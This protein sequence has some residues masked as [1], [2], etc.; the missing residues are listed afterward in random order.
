MH[1]QLFAITLAVSL[2]AAPLPALAVGS[3]QASDT[4][5]GLATTV[6]ASGLA[7][8][9]ADIVVRSP[10]G[11]DVPLSTQVDANGNASVSIPGNALEEAGVYEVTV[12]QQSVPLPASAHFA[13]K[14]G[15][16]DA[17]NSAVEA[18]QTQVSAGQTTEVRV[19]LRDRYANPLAGR[20]V[21]LVA[22]RPSDTV[23]QLTDLTDAAGMQRFSVQVREAGQTTLTAL[24]LLS[25]T[26]VDAR[27]TLW[28]GGMAAMGGDALIASIVPTAHAQSVIKGFELTLPKIA[29]LKEPFA[30][31]IRAVDAQGNL[32]PDYT[33]SVYVSVSNDANAIL[34]GI[35]TDRDGYGKLKFLVQSQGDLNVPAA[36]T[37]TQAGLHEIHVEDTSNP[38][39]SGSAKIIANSTGDAGT[40]G[41]IEILSPRS[42]VA[43]LQVQVTGKA[44]PLTNLTVEGGTS[45]VTTQSDA[46][47]NFAAYVQL[48]PGSTQATMKVSDQQNFLTPATVTVTVD[49]TGP[50][51]RGVTF[52]P[53]SP[54]AGA[55]VLAMTQLSDTDIKSVALVV[56]GQTV[57]FTQNPSSPSL[58]Q[59]LFVAPA[60]EDTYSVIT[61]ATDEA[62]NAGTFESSLT[63][64]PK[65]L[66]QV[67]NV[68]AEPQINAVKLHWTASSDQVERYRIYIGDADA[69][70]TNQEPVFA[71]SIDTPDAT[72]SAVVQGLM[73]GTRYLFAVTGLLGNRES[74]QKSTTVSAVPDG[75]KL[76]VIPGDSALTLAWDFPNAPTLGAFIVKFGAS[77]DDLSEQRVINPALKQYRLTDLL[78]GVQYS[79]Q[80]VPVTIEGKQLTDIAAIGEGTPTGNGFSAAP[81]E[82]IPDQE[83]PPLITMH[84]GAKNPGSGLPPVAWWAALAF[85]MIAYGFHRKQKREKRK[86]RAF[87]RIMEERYRN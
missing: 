76:Q 62:G 12:E 3:I 71:K 73:P 27:A 46:E 51:V 40:S 37:F 81:V 19:T 54:E 48:A 74:T 44:A 47:G 67:Q 53:P 36:L 75:I 84:P 69:S 33:G 63:V 42:A 34:P 9:D 35:D 16:V 20:P 18:Q 24:D 13:V 8:G 45:P 2:C 21:H 77:P 29:T 87:A 65:G 61:T 50:S 55:N 68:Q 30:F 4:F 57:L 78:P 5:A 25:N 22:T 32:V 11:A 79:L 23:T 82:Q 1:K 83:R 80:L 15:A 41:R 70:E 64:V 31:S 58:Y 10:S 59:A 39:I 66:A 6:H 72:T 7:A 52:S 85:T 49:A 60:R 14:P 56:D 17:Q 86:L 26:V 28:T 38:S 43:G